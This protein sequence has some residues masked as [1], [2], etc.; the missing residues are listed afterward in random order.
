MKNEKNVGYRLIVL[1]IC[2]ALGVGFIACAD[3]PEVDEG[4]TDQETR[5]EIVI[6]LPPLTG[7]TISPDVIDVLT[8]P[9]FL[10][11]GQ[12]EPLVTNPNEESIGEQ[13]TTGHRYK[14]GDVMNATTGRRCATPTG[15]VP[16]NGWTVTYGGINSLCSYPWTSGYYS[17]CFYPGACF[18]E[19]EYTSYYDIPVGGT[20]RFCSAAGVPAGWVVT[21]MNLTPSCPGG[22][23]SIMQHVSCISG[24]D[25]NCYPQSASISASPKTLTIP[26][27]QSAGSTTI[28]WNTTNY[29]NP[30]VWIQNSGASS[31]SLWACSGG[32]AHSATWPYVP[33]GGTTTL[34]ISNGGSSSPS[35]NVAQVVVTGLAGAAPTI[36][37]SPNP[38]FI[39]V[40]KSTGS[41]TVSWNAAGYSS[42]SVYVSMDGGAKSLMASSGTTGTSTPNWIQ[43]GHSYSFSLHPTGNTAT[44]L[45]SVNVQGKQLGTW[46]NMGVDFGPCGVLTST[47]TVGDQVSAHSGPGTAGGCYIYQCK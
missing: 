46:V 38:V 45:T 42:T 20:L 25:T 11:E 47:C 32:G 40:G 29:S 9:G 16:P 30:C 24:R 26:Y 27:G 6:D 3:A 35:P 37:A 8:N 1:G 7:G 41:T 13:K 43:G 15:P 31:P 44:T 19:Y 36:S 33:Y 34:W 4:G 12:D 22:N 23:D 18:N 14:S 21:Q 10:D 39:P 2:G 28:S 17:I 5:Q